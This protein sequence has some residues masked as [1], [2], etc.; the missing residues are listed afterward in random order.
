MKSRKINWTEKQSKIKK[1]RS[2]KSK[3]KIG[4]KFGNLENMKKKMY[5]GSES[6]CSCLL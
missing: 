3:E 5:V 6:Q 2:K 1:R 4:K